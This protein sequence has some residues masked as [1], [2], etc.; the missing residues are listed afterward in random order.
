MILQFQ[1]PKNLAFVT[2]FSASRLDVFLWN[3]RVTLLHSPLFAAYMLLLLWLRTPA[4]TGLVVSSSVDVFPF[5][6]LFVYHMFDILSARMGVSGIFVCDNGLWSESM[7]VTCYFAYDWNW[8]Y[9]CFAI[10]EGKNWC[11]GPILM[12]QLTGFG[13]LT[14]KTFTCQLNCIDRGEE[15][16]KEEI[17]GFCPCIRLHGCL[18][19]KCVSMG[20]HVNEYN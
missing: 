5:S 17:C 6:N 14:A 19:V 20:S 3:P 9:F 8:F 16:K 4:K 13:F 7:I 18:R 15:C 11:L 2:F 1:R 12:Q 10:V